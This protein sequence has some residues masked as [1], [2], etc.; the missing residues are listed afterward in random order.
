MQERTGFLGC[1]AGWAHLPMGILG[2][3]MVEEDPLGTQGTEEGLAK[4]VFTGQRLH[5][6]SLCRE[7]GFNTT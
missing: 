4:G 6:K 3:K 5:R 7:D 2:S 1:G